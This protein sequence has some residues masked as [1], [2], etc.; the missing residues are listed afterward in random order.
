MTRFFIYISILLFGILNSNTLTGQKKSELLKRQEKILLEKIEHTK[1]LID[2]TR[3]TKKLTLSEI[4]IVNKQIK[5][6]QK[7]IDNYNIQLRRMDEK[8]QEINRQV[9]SL[10]N[11]NKIL[12]EN[13]DSLVLGI[14]QFADSVD[15]NENINSKYSLCP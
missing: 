13:D 11:T 15:F 14:N 6:R 1:V 8:I 3:A 2:Q 9:N 4:N 10:I 12:S 7:L 5:Y